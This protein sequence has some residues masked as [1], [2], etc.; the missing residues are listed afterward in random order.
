M[1]IEIL[2]RAAIDLTD[3]FYFYETQQS[4][5]GDYFLNSLYSDIESLQIYAGIHRK[6]YKDYHR[7]LSK[8]FPFA[9]FYKTSNNSVFIYAVVDCRRDES[10]IKARLK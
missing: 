6:A 10:W 9:V 5:L 3:G 2:D 7:L 8:R 4:G 1:R